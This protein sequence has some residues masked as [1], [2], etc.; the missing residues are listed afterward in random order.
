M[1]AGGGYGVSVATP[2]PVKEPR[3]GKAT[4]VGV[5]LN[6]TS[7][8]GGQTRADATHFVTRQV[9]RATMRRDAGLI[10]N[11]VGNPVSDAGGERLIEQ[12]R[13]YRRLAPSQQLRE[14]RE[15]R[16]VQQ[17]VKPETANGRF[18]FG[19]VQQT[20]ATEATR[21]GHGQTRAVVGKQLAFHIRG[22]VTL[23]TIDS[24]GTG[25]AEM[26]GGPGSSVE[27]EP[28]NLA[29]AMNAPHST[30]AQGGGKASR[31]DAGV[32]DPIVGGRDTRDA[33]TEQRSF[34]NASAALD[35]GEF[36]HGFAPTGR[37]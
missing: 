8:D 16:Q 27:F 6:G 13:L 30:T 9:A 32:D 21:I 18:G 37:A 22:P 34:G 11:L 15:R 33:A 24:E 4:F 31:R 28:E 5:H 17:W 35:F 23:V 19:V 12:Y 10:Q 29:A 25:H 26:E 7:N 36:R 14:D 2:A 1:V 3:S 20:N